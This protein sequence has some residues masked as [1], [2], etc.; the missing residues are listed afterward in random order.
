MRFRFCGDLDCPDWV[1]AEISILS[2]ISSVK[3]KLFCQQIMSH[4]INGQI[5][6]AKVSKFTSD[7]KFDIND[8]KAA[9]AAVDFIFSSGAKY[10][11]DG[12]TL[13]NELQQ[14]GL[15]KEL[16]ASLCKVYEDKFDSLHKVLKNKSLRLSSL[17]SVDWRVDYVLVSNFT[18]NV[19]EPEVQ[20]K[21]CKTD[22]EEPI[23]FTSSGDKFRV[24]LSE[25]REAYKHM[26]ELS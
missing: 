16:A 7:A 26:E 14:L 13:S 5:D 1:L 4:L 12:E 21:I 18:D 17:K 8:I 2:K 11:V 22:D 9:I 23:C 19:K 6:Y 10:G 3:M 24:L 20:L 15:P 25:M